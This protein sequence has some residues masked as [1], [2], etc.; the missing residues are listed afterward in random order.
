MYARE[1]QRKEVEDAFLHSKAAAMRRRQDEEARRAKEKAE[2]ERRQRIER[3]MLQ[4]NPAFV[5]VMDRAFGSTMTQEMS[6]E[7]SQRHV[8]YPPTRIKIV[9]AY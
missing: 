7:V 2:A 6:I 8:Y 4:T 1:L 3:E 9:T 5:E